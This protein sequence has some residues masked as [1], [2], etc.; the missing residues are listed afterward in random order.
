VNDIA[1]FPE[2]F[3]VRDKLPQP[4]DE[5]RARLHAWGLA[6]PG[7][8]KWL[9]QQAL[10]IWEKHPGSTDAHHARIDAVAALDLLKWRLDVAEDRDAV[11]HLN[12]PLAKPVKLPSLPPSVD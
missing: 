10:K 12:L 6:Q 9:V 2:K 7:S 4:T 5:T 3:P 8:L 1:T 11:A